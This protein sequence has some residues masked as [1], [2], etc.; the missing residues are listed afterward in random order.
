MHSGFRWPSGALTWA[1]LA[2]SAWTV[3]SGLVGLTLQRWVPQVLAS[4]LSVE[5]LYQRA[6]ELVEGLRRRSARLVEAAG[7]PVSTLYEHGLAERFAS[8]QPRWV[9]LFDI[10]GGQ[11]SLRRG[12]RHLAGRI[13]DDGRRSLDELEEL[14]RTK[15][16]IDASYTLQR[17]LRWWIWLHAPTSFLL[18]AVVAV[19]IGG[20]LYY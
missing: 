10:T 9:Y 4:G 11:Q 20:S 5:V 19:H 7:P 18:I 12:F 14:L 15:M 2:L 6:P 1:L 17:V 13:D 8:L 16:E 3:A